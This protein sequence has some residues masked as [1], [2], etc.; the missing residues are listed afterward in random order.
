[1]TAKSPNPD[2]L[3]SIE[4]CDGVRAW[5]TSRGDGADSRNHYS[6]FNI[7]HYTGDSEVH[8]TSCRRALC[9]AIGITPQRLVVP[10]QT[11][12]INCVTIDSVPVDSG[13]L[14]GTDAI[15]T[16]LK[17]VAIGISTADCVPVLMADPVNHIIAA[18]H[19]GWRGAVGGIVTVALERMIEIGADIS[20]LHVAMGPCICSRCFEVGEEVASQFPAHC[21]D[22]NHSTG[23][24]HVDLAAYL[25]Q[26]LIEAGIGAD[27]IRLPGECTRCNPSRLFSA[28]AHGIDSGRIFTFVMQ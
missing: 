7:C 17:G 19:A 12:S 1:M 28:R 27:N 9:R 21:V 14:Q 3:N 2:W 10:R 23:K 26:T 6:Q 22:R 11:H 13:A 20:C 15:V 8:T 25:R 18:V 5:Y 16:R 24:P 4:L